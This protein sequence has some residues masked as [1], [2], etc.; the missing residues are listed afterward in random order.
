MND[1]EENKKPI[2]HMD[3]LLEVR[4]AIREG[5]VEWS[6]QWIDAFSRMKLDDPDFTIRDITVNFWGQWEENDGGMRISWSTESA[7]FGDCDFW[8]KDGKLRCGNER[9]GRKF[10]LSVLQKFLEDCELDD[11]SGD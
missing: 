5:N 10:I 3:E 2:I 4:Q 8:I 7:G 9:M 1:K 11:E 6:P